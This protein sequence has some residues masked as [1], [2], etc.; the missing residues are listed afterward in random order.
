MGTLDSIEEEVSVEDETDKIVTEESLTM[1]TTENQ[2]VEDFIGKTRLLKLSETRLLKRL[3]IEENPK[4]EIKEKILITIAVI[5]ILTSFVTRILLTTYLEHDEESNQSFPRTIE[6][7]LSTEERLDDTQTHL[8]DLKMVH[9]IGTSVTGLLLLPHLFLLGLLP[10]KGL[11]LIA[12]LIVSVVILAVG[13]FNEHNQVLIGVYHDHVGDSCHTRFSCNHASVSAVLYVINVFFVVTTIFRIL[14]QTKYRPNIVNLKCIGPYIEFFLSRRSR[15]FQSLTM[16]LFLTFAVVSGAVLHKRQRFNGLIHNVPNR[17]TEIIVDAV[18]TLSMVC[19]LLL[20]FWIYAQIH[21][22]YTHT[23]LV[24]KDV[25][26]EELELLCERHK[27]ALTDVKKISR[28][29]YNPV[30]MN[31]DNPVNSGHEFDGDI[32][33][34]RKNV[35]S[36]MFQS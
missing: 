26:E 28:F 2:D 17:L 16:L 1:T 15:D 21:H 6:R 22:R 10:E 23:I 29:S 34:K 30:S 4:L 18:S 25:L 35:K 19:W 32:F 9:I 36:S 20:L 12:Q 11:N 8:E 33:K 7:M 5:L 14:L 27:Q 31:P 3:K 13:A 24:K